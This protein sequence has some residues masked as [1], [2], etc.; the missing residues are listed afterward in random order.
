MTALPSPNYPTSEGLGAAQALA[1]DGYRV[2]PVPYGSKVPTLR[3]WPNVATSD[4]DAVAR[5]FAGGPWNIG[6][7]TGHGLVVVDIDVKHG[8]DGF[9][10]LKTLEAKL[11][12]LPIT[13]TVRTPSGGLHIY[14]RVSAAQRVPNSSGKLGPGIDVRGDGGYV[15]AP[16]SY[17]GPS[18]YV[19]EDDEPQM[20]CPR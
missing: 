10:S 7:A 4:P 5:L 16:G 12:K 1:A 2:F 15:L 14:L 17:V 6:I 11:G 19:V 18:A 8:V 9:A 20:E 13:R 3:D